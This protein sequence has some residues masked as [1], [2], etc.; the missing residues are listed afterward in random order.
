MS[1]QKKSGEIVGGS[2][3]KTVEIVT[4]AQKSLEKLLAA[5]IIKRWKS[6]QVLKIHEFSIN[7]GN[8]L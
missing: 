7:S 1:A 3:N 2:Y 8:K 5:A 6:S 4:S